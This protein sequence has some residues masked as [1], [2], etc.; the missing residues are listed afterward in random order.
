M[1]RSGDRLHIADACAAIWERMDEW[2]HDDHP[3]SGQT[4]R[5]VAQ[6][7]RLAGYHVVEPGATTTRRTRS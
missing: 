6:I 1:T 4:V 2:W 5:D 7:L 3:R